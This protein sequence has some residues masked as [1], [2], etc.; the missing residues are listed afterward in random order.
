ME[1]AED[2]LQ[3]LETRD[4]P[5]GSGGLTPIDPQCLESGGVSALHVVLLAVPDVQNAVHILPSL[6]G[7]PTPKAGGTP[8]RRT[9]VS[10]KVSTTLQPCSP[11][12]CRL[13]GRTNAGWPTLSLLWY[14]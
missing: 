5:V 13:A 3:F 6:R 4:E 7:N 1:T 9:S 10:W 2:P 12:D 11:A 8:A 14:V